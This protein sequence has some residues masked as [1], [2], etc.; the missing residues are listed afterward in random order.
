MKVSKLEIIKIFY[1]AQVSVELP[2]TWR[3]CA[4][5]LPPIFNFLFPPRYFHTV[6]IRLAHEVSSIA[7]ILFA[8]PEFASIVSSDFS[9][10]RSPKFSLLSYVLTTEEDVVVR[11]GSIEMKR[12]AGF[13]TTCYVYDGFIALNSE[14]EGGNI[15]SALQEFNSKSE[16][17][18]IVKD[19]ADSLTNVCCIALRLLLAGKALELS[20]DGD[21]IY[22]VPGGRMCLYN[23]V[24]NICPEGGVVFESRDGPFCVRDFNQ[25]Q[26]TGASGASVPQLVHVPSPTFGEGKYVC[27]QKTSTGHHFFSLKCTG[28]SRLVIYDDA[29]RRPVVIDRQSFSDFSTSERGLF[30]FML[31]MVSTRPDCS[32]PLY[33]A[34]GGGLE[35]GSAAIPRSDIRTSLTRCVLCKSR[36]ARYEVTRVKIVSHEGVETRKHIKLRC[37]AKSCR[38]IFGSNYYVESRGRLINTI[39]DAASLGDVLL[40]VGNVGFKTS[41]LRVYLLASR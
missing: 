9:R 31:S 34:F 22:T 29:V 1:G 20:G 15:E 7:D 37:C 2:L 24:R 10:R 25:R 40:L 4:A 3:V 41:Y 32:D 26:T 33:Y 23:A 39:P 35:R 14:S 36:L 17:R 12:L 16:A 8:Y 18:L 13:D 30:F 38:R 5:K 28:G 27:L 21:F 11:A 6:L 19:W